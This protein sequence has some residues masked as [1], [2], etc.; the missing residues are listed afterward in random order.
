MKVMWRREHLD[1]AR[2]PP[3]CA[4]T[5]QPAEGTARV[6][7]GKRWAMF[8][9]SFVRLVIDLTNRPVVIN[10]P[11][12]GPVQRSFTRHSKLS[13]LTLLGIVLA[14]A[15]ALA[16]RGTFGSL[17][18][19]V[20]LI[21]SL[22][23]MIFI[24][25]KLNIVGSDIENGWLVMERAAT[26]FGEAMAASNPAGMVQLLESGQPQQGAA[27]Q[28]SSPPQHQ[29]GPQQQPYG[30]AGPN[31]APPAYGQPQQ[32][33]GQPQQPY[34][35]LPQQPY[36]QPQQQYGQPHQQYG[37]PPQQYGQPHQQYEQPHEQYGNPQQ[38][39]GNHQQQY[40]NHQQ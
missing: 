4:V 20:F 27:V 7:F 18:F 3:I 36:G 22:G 1:T 5:G 19:F 35:Q 14:F 37:Q 24:R 25:S 11:V 33:Y 6:W 31:G 29:A 8:M 17:L 38:Q 21:A 39:Y 13:L 9:P 30:A 26:P 23:W 34:G 28:P 15:S 12:S 10:V 2:M 16:L 40:G 32:Q